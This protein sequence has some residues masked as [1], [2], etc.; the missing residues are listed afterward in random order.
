MIQLIY[1]SFSDDIV[2]KV[3]QAIRYTTPF[4]FNSF[5]KY[6]LKLQKAKFTSEMYEVFCFAAI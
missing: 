4:K 5:N 6:G 3:A 1:S 2:L